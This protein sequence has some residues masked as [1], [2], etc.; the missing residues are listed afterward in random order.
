M[1]IQTLLRRSYYT[2]VLEW[3]VPGF[4]CWCQRHGKPELALCRDIHT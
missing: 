4:D 1:T 3:T 2:C